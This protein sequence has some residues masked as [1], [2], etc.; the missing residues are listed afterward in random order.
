MFGV[1]NYAAIPIW[2]GK[3][4]LN[5]LTSS[6]RLGVDRPIT[7]SDGL[8]G[9][10]LA[11]DRTV[12]KFSVAISAA[13]YLAKLY[14]DF[15]YRESWNRITLRSPNELIELF[16][17]SHGGISIILDIPNAA[18]MDYPSWPGSDVVGESHC[19]LA[20]RSPEGKIVMIDP[21]IERGNRLYSQYV[22]DLEAQTFCYPLD[23]N[24][25]MVDHFMN[26]AQAIS[27][28]SLFSRKIKLARESLCL[29]RETIAAGLNE[30]V[31]SS[32]IDELCSVDN[33][34]PIFLHRIHRLSL[35]DTAFWG[36]FDRAKLECINRSCHKLADELLIKTY[37][38]S[39]E[40]RTPSR[41][42]RA[43]A[44]LQVSKQKIYESLESFYDALDGEIGLE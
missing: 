7:Y 28:D 33:P 12:D 37:R 10:F 41:G 20:I 25:F 19:I 36:S 18:F 30:V 1:E 2:A 4:S 14:G 8:F 35:S 15:N 22:D 42:L 16:H 9:G 23:I 34:M 39:L 29:G 6:L 5:C 24:V 38:L 17:S 32:D 27:N 3:N 40:K 21:S 43:R 44:A 26:R 31:C 11:V 13:E